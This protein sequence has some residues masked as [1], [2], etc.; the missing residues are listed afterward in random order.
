[1]LNGVMKPATKTIAQLLEDEPH[2]SNF[3]AR[4]FHSNI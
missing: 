2:F 4:Q 1:M 3:R